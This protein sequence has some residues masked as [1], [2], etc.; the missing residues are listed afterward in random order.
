MANDTLCQWNGRWRVYTCCI[1]NVSFSS[2][3][4]SDWSTVLSPVKSRTKPKSVIE[5][6][7]L[8]LHWGMKNSLHVK[9]VYWTSLNNPMYYVW[10]SGIATNWIFMGPMWTVGSPICP[11]GMQTKYVSWMVLARLP[12]DLWLH[13]SIKFV[14]ISDSTRSSKPHIEEVMHHDGNST[15]NFTTM[16]NMKS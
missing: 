14:Q 11:H 10:R 15:C 1:C 16:C 12:C 5:L 4:I 3:S 7:L 8:N 9:W 2:S 6:L 13:R